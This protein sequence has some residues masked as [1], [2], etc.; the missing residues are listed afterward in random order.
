M[1]RDLLKEIYDREISPE[2]AETAFQRILRSEQGSLVY[3][4]LRITKREATAFLHG[5]TF[6]DL[7]KWRYE[8]W[9]NVCARCGQEID[10][11]AFGWF[12]GEEQDG[13][14]VLV[15]LRCPGT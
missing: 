11:D 8:G 6:A 12:A 2:D 3:D 9:P 14:S 15:H 7:A 13:N 10:L 4:L 1:S 5:V